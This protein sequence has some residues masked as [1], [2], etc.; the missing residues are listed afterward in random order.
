MAVEKKMHC[1]QKPYLNISEEE[2]KE[3][4]GYDQSDENIFK[5]EQEVQMT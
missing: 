3:F 5:K 1:L 2:W 4:W